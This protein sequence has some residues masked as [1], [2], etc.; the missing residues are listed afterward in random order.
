MIRAVARHGA[1]DAQVVGVPSRV[2]Q[3]I[4]KPPSARSVTFPFPWSGHEV[5]L[6]VVENAPD[7]VLVFLEGR[8]YRLAVQ[9]LQCRLVVQEVES[10]W[11]AILKKEDYAFRLGHEVGRPLDQRAEW[12]DLLRAGGSRRSFVLQQVG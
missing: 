3:E 6:A 7:L 8:G 2:R 10:R 12:I 4:G 9:S 11:S 1:H 5:V